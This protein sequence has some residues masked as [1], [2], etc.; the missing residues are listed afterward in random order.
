MVLVKDSGQTFKFL[1]PPPAT[2]RMQRPEGGT[3]KGV[4]EKRK[5]RKKGKREG[6]KPHYPY[7][8]FT[9]SF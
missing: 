2:A 4:W 3:Q 7:S 6:C 5:K 8:L 9:P 1:L